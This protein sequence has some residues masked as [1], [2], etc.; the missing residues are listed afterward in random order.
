MAPVKVSDRHASGSSM[1]LI[2]AGR[3]RPSGEPPFWCQPPQSPVR[4]PA[5]AAEPGSASTS[6]S[7]LASGWW[8]AS[9][10]ADWP[11]SLSIPVTVSTRRVSHCSLPGRRSAGP[12]NRLPDRR[13]RPEDGTKIEAESNE[14]SGVSL[15]GTEHASDVTTGSPW[16]NAPRCAVMRVL[17]GPGACRSASAF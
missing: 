13:A 11:S 15:A 7:G 12:R 6:A 2:C 10:R 3:D 17:P 1:T 16:R 5:V 9:M 4:S 14:G 8:C